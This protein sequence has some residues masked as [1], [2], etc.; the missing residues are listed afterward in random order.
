MDDDEKK[1]QR[2]GRPF[3]KGESGNPSGRPKGALNKSTLMA[4]ALLADK[5]GL[6]M[7]KL[8][9]DVER[10]DR[11]AIRFC[12][13]RLI[14]AQRERPVELELGE[15]RNAADAEAEYAKIYKGVA[16]RDMSAT[17]GEKMCRI[18]DGFLKVRRAAKGE[19]PIKDRMF[20]ELFP[21]PEALKMRTKEARQE[22]KP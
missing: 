12:A 14:P 18:I 8:F 16:D 9:E 21:I 19:R 1:A 4:E 10:G 5:T 15:L 2:R 7:R 11:V 3:T 20:E 17:Q 13:S 6:V 22:N